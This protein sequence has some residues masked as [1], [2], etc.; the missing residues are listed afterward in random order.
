MSVEVHELRK[1]LHCLLLEAP[2][3]VC[4]DVSKLAEAALKATR[5][6]ALL[7]VDAEIR[8]AW[9]RLEGWGRETWGKPAK[10]GPG[11]EMVRDL[12]KEIADHP[13]PKMQRH[14]ADECKPEKENEDG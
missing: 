1:A 9:K 7:E 13:N 11:L 4:R 3:A 12:L 14:K 8:A 2:E 6:D 5:R 10:Y